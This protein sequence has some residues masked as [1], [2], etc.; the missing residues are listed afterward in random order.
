MTPP[1]STIPG[2]GIWSAAANVLAFRRDPLGFMERL[3]ARFGPVVRVRFAWLTQYFINDPGLARQILELPHTAA[4]K[5][6]RSVQL[7]GRIAG[8]SVL[9]AN[10]APWFQRRRLLQ[11]LFHHQRM[12][13]Y[14]ELMGQLCHEMLERWKSRPQIAAH[15]EM[16]RLTFTFIC[17]VVFAGAPA[18]AAA[19]MQA[20]VTEML[21]TIWKTILSPAQTPLWPGM[22]SRRRFDRALAELDDFIFRQIRE[23]REQGGD[24]G[25][26]LQMLLDCRDADTG[27][28]M[29]DEDIRNECITMLIAGHETT[30]NA[31]TWSLLLLAGHPDIREPVR[32]E[33][34]Q[35]CGDGPPLPEH[36][37]QLQRTRAV[38]M[39][40]MRLYPPIWLIERNLEAPF[41]C[42]DWS[43]P[44][45]AQ[46]LISPHILHRLPAFWSEPDK[47]N[48]D[49]FLERD[50]E[51]NPAFLPFGTG[52]RVCIG[53]N[54]ATREGIVFLAVIVRGSRLERADAAPVAPAP[55]ISLRPAREILL[56]T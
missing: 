5:H 46:L 10:G 43:L 45:G 14:P 12:R 17:R 13:S 20:P 48:P 32:T 39:E 1:S 11:P 25:D 6:T 34:Q 37:P 30:A 40:A 22:A 24:H 27:E 49:R 50:A 28:A 51:D 44:A 41:A 8:T 2:P 33:V 52:P 16:T 19:E 36:L 35:V 23:R 21:A 7:L 54:L 4:N 53:R 3:A 9:T 31:L 55:G 47:F 42:G 18:S 38:L 26:L 56:Q 29:S 15:E